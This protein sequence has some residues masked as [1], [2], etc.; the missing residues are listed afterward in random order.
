MAC[1]AVTACDS[2]TG[3]S[4]KPPLPGKRLAVLSFEK[5]LAAEAGS[6]DIRLPRPVVNASWP[7]AGGFP[8]HAMHHVEAGDQ[9]AKAWSV[10]VGTGSSER[11]RLV[12]APVV[13]AGKVF[14]VDAEGNVSA[15]DARTGAKLWQ[16]GIAPDEEDGDGNVGGG[17]A[18]EDG[19]LFVATGYGQVVALKADTGEQVWRRS[20]SSPVRGA[21]A[22]RG[23]RVIVQAV[24]NQTH[25][26]A[27]DDG[28]PLWRHT[29]IGEVASLLGGSSPAIDG[30][31][32][33][34]AYSSGEV[35]ALR[36]EN[37]AVLWTDSLSSLRRTDS[38]AILTDIRGL[39]VIG[40]ERVFAIGNSDTLTAIDLRSG[41]RLWEREIGGTQTPW[42]AGDYLYVVSNDQELVALEAKTGRILW[43][44][45]LQRWKD[46]KDRT[47]YVTW[48]G[49]VLAGDRLIVSSSHGWA[50]SISPYTGQVIGKETLPE[51][52][53]TSPVVADRAVYFLTED[54]ELVAYR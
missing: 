21:P 33:V 6:G 10:S 24:D 37:G 38:L 51:G 27:A 43:V 49:P 28:R 30:N 15:V 48:A 8:H 2:L 5:T 22:V 4:E 29:G 11:S 35:V 23:G 3:E 7:Q 18:Y 39:P 47:G 16:V 36:I 19:R 17:V 45:P 44:S 53:V 9:L 54:A 20:V 1:L 26:L 41:R 32:V 31:V 25:A 12:S 46:T 40:G 14:A 52:V 34:V 42:L 13:A 50:L